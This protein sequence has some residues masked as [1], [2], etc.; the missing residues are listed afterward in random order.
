MRLVLA[1]AAI[2]H[3]VILVVL[4]NLANLMPVPCAAAQY[5]ASESTVLCSQGRANK[6]PVISYPASQMDPALETLNPAPS[7]LTGCQL[8]HYA[9]PTVHFI[10][11]SSTYSSNRSCNIGAQP[12]Q[13]DDSLVWVFL[14]A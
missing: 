11:H 10:P 5:Y 13:Y 4:L 9:L 14:A 1:A 6:K 2:A 3:P 8:S 12:L 7:S